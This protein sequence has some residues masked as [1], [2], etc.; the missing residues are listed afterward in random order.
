[1]A[2]STESKRPMAGRR[3]RGTPKRRR[4][5]EWHIPRGPIGSAGGGLEFDRLAGKFLLHERFAC[6]SLTESFGRSSTD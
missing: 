6:H 2:H 4:R 3:R 1:M 5:D